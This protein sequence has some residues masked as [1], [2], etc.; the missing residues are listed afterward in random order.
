MF[1]TLKKELNIK[2]VL[3]YVTET[4]YKLTGTDTWIPEDDICPS[5][6]HSNC[7][8]IKDVGINEEA[9]AKCFSEGTVWDVISIVAT[10]KQISNVDAA[11]LLAKH[12]E[13]KLPLD[14]SPMQELFNLA[15]NYYHECFITAGP[16]AELNGLTPSEYQTQIRGHT[17]ESITL[18][19]VGWSD[20]GLIKY[21]ESVGIDAD[22]IKASGLQGKKGDFLPSKVFVYPHMVRGRTSHFTFKDVLKQKEFQLPK[23]NSLNGVVFYNQDSINKQGTIAICEGE[24]DAISISEAGWDS[25]ILC[26]NGSISGEQ[27]EWLTTNGK[28]RDLLTFF[29]ADP[30][31][32]NY[33]DKVEKLR[34]S[35][36]SLTHIK[37]SGQVKDIDEYLKKGGNFQALLESGTQASDKSSVEID[38]E[39][40]TLDANA[41]VIKNGA[42]YKVVYKDGNESL[43]LLTNFTME[44]LNVYIRG[45]ERE[46]EVILSLTNGRKSPSFIISSEAKVSLKA[47][48]TLIANAIDASFY[49]SEADLNSIWEKVYSMSHEKTVYLLEQVGRVDTFSGWVFK[50]CFIADTGEI[51]EPDP[52]GVMWVTDKTGIKPVSIIYGETA[53]DNQIGVP[54]IMSPLSKEERKKMIHDVIHA[55]AENLGDMGEA[56]TIMGW[57]W[58]TVHSK[59]LFDRIRFFPHLQFFGGMGRGKSWLIKMFLDMFNM[60]APAYTSIVNLNSGVAFSRKMSY[61]TSLPM[62]IDE[63]RNDQLTVDWYGAFRS[64]YDR[65]GRA[66]GTKEGFGIRMFPVRSTLIFGG[67]DLFTDPATR[68]RCIPIRLRKNNRETIKSFKVLEDNRHEINAIGYEWILGYKDIEKSKLLEDFSIFEKFLLKSAV[69][70]RQARNWAVVGVF[71]NML[72]KEYCPGFNYMESL[73]KVA[74]VNQEE[75]AEDSTLIQFWMDVE[76]MQS[77]ER[78]VITNDHMRRDGNLLY[79]WYSEVFRLF[80]KDTSFTNKQKFS[81]NAIL[82]S[83]KEEGYYVG[84]DR[85]VI[86]MA[87]NSRRCIILDVSKSPEPIQTISDFLDN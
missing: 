81:K 13:V 15:T 27:L 26:C 51:F 42:Y 71:A 35:F 29:D 44:L 83:L 28:D 50:D 57:C 49:G 86:G 25:G 38:D 22:I 18:F 55:L 17:P 79:V 34:R 52:T 67:E 59:T 23:R 76:G 64:W 73:V 30:A 82:S 72:S 87:G 20:G 48:K 62:C 37:V 16:A 46:R 80:Q 45:M 77:A 53:D 39:G 1:S 14:Y 6:G 12:Y 63:I 54:S 66:I 78:P 40:G 75:Q 56:L 11:K 19:N 7:F 68:S 61:Y 5:C 36:K 31:G 10:L 33:R 32:D 8:R 21:L 24:N 9:F 2:D 4:T 3:E 43:R 41:I 69:E 70:S 65:S 74:A 60:E 84:A 85:K 47:F 58:A